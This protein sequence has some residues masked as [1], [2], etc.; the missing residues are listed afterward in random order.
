MALFD[1]NDLKYRETCCLILSSNSRF[2]CTTTVKYLPLALSLFVKAPLG[3]FT[4]GSV[5]SPELIF[6]MGGFGNRDGTAL[7]FKARLLVICMPI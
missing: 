5:S 1:V 7:V 6:S 4:G 3:R 2:Y